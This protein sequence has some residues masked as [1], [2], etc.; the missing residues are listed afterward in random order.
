MW[1]LLLPTGAL[2]L[3]VLLTPKKATAPTSKPAAP[4]GLQPGQSYNITLNVTAPDAASAQ[5][6]AGDFLAHQG[7]LA[8]QFTSTQPALGGTFVL[9]YTGPYAGGQSALQSVPPVV[10]Y[11]VASASPPV[12]YGAPT[13]LAVPGQVQ[14]Q[15]G[16][17]YLAKAVVTAPLSWV[18]TESAIKGKLGE[19]GFNPVSVWTSDPPP[20]FPDTTPAPSGD[21][22]W[23]AADWASPTQ[24][25]NAPSQLQGAWAMQPAPASKAVA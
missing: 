1:W 20:F 5:L 2:A 11:S 9:Q 6:A 22:Y 14:L 23:I 17:R 18:V 3:Y 7:F 8:G 15:P 25:M 12:T 21:T 10:V 24:S 19:L 16:V 13:P 4:S